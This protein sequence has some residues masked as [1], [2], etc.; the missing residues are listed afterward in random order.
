MN[1]DENY[2]KLTKNENESIR[3]FFKKILINNQIKIICISN[4]TIIKLFWPLIGEQVYKVS[5]YE[6]L[7]K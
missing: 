5:E 4:N 2:R 3:L 6:I 1:I 7:D